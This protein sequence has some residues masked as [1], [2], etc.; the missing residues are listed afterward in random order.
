[1]ISPCAQPIATFSEPAFV[2]GAYFFSAAKYLS[3]T[4]SPGFRM[5]TQASLTMPSVLLGLANPIRVVLLQ[6]K[7][8]AIVGVQPASATASKIC[9]HLVP[10]ATTIRLS[11]PVALRV[12]TCERTVGSVTW[13]VSVPTSSAPLSSMLFSTP[14]CAAS[15]KVPACRMRATFFLP[16]S[17]VT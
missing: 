9:G 7:V 11:A 17:P 2:F 8:V 5:R 15:P 12:V 16:S 4:S 3:D 10:A 6:V 1:M 14:R 13:N